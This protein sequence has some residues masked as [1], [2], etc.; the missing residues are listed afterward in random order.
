MRRK[1]Y[2]ILAISHRKAVDKS[3]MTSIIDSGLRTQDELCTNK[4]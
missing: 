1:V 4:V 2:A 3:I